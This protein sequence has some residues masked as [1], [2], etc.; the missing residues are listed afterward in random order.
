MKKK[1]MCVSLIVSLIGLSSIYAAEKEQARREVIIGNTVFRYKGLRKFLESAEKRLRFNLQ[2]ENFVISLPDREASLDF[3]TSL[4][5]RE[6]SLE[7]SLDGQL[8]IE[9]SNQQDTP[10][11]VACFNESLTFFSKNRLT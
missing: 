4:P 6:V 1:F 10:R 2:F 3:V 11:L 9:G 5:D 8:T 7:I